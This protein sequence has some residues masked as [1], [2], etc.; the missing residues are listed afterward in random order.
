MKSVLFTVPVLL[1][2]FSVA[3]WSSTGHVFLTGH[4]PDYHASAGGNT[5]GAQHIIQDGINFADGGTFVRALLVTDLRNP[6]GDQSDSR[7]GMNAAGYTGLYDIA[8]YGSGTLGVLDLHTVDFSLY[9]VVVIASDY[10]GWLRQDELDILNA[11]RTDLGNY[12]FGGGGLVAFAEG[13]DRATG[14]DPSIYPGTS[15][16]RYGY[17][18][19]IV[20]SAAL[21]QS[22]SGVTVTSF[23]ASLGLTAG[24]VNGNASHNIFT[25]TAG[26]NVVDNDAAGDILSLAGDYTPSLSQTPEPS[27]I[28]LLAIGLIAGIGRLR[29][30]NKLEV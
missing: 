5:A 15:H 23:G 12:L 18:P 19:A 20:S 8:D 3:G 26:L 2:V 27:T 24:D 9:S 16:D 10:G 21:N 13:G 11:R 22:E 28:S 17:L 7:L 4:D 29:K 14:G 25:N 30:K 6:G 1:L